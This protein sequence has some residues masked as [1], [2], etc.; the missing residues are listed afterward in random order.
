MD[1]TQPLPT[2]QGNPYGSQPV[3]AYHKRQIGCI[4]ILCIIGGLGAFLGGIGSVLAGVYDETSNIFTGIIWITIGLA[5]LW[6]QVEDR[7][8]YLLLTTGPCRWALCGCGKEKFYY[9]NIRD[10]A[11]TQTC[12]YGFGIHSCSSV[13]LFN[14]CSCCCGGGSCCG[15]K[16]VRLTI[17]ERPQGLGAKDSG[18]CCWESCCL[19]CFCG[20]RRHYIGKG[21]CFQSLCNPCNANCCAINTVF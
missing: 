2:H 16:T 11:V 14:N 12:F 19:S 3:I 13:K 4:G 18:D 15:H 9:R 17:N 7:G 6:I 5:M 10:Y 20:E 1:G 21:C 8:E